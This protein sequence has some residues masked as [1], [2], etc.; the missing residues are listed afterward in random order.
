MLITSVDKRQF[1]SYFKGINVFAKILGRFKN[2]RDFSML[3]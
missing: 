3:W 1:P 2:N